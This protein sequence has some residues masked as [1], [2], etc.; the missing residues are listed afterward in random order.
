M[1]VLNVLLNK[2]K[3]ISSECLRNIND[4]LWQIISG[5]ISFLFFYEIIKMLVMMMIITIK[6]CAS[7][8]FP[9]FLTLIKITV[10]QNS[11]IVSRPRLEQKDS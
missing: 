5:A 7:I 3:T 9:L 11:I 2:I 4:G 8:F 6:T 1:M 10:I